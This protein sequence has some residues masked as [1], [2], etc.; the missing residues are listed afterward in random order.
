ML[1][2]AACNY[3]ESE[4]PIRGGRSAWRCV[5]V[6]FRAARSAARAGSTQRPSA[7]RS[8]YPRRDART[9]ELLPDRTHLRRALLR[10]ARRRHLDARG[11]HFVPVAHEGEEKKTARREVEFESQR[12]KRALTAPTAYSASHARTS[13]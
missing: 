12:G 11:A 8:R 13:L 2:T 7:R 5:T 9:A 1:K 4:Q 10:S 3:Y 6:L